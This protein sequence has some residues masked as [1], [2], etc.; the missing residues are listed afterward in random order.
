MFDF[1]F[2]VLVRCYLF[3]SFVFVGLYLEVCDESRGPT[4]R[5]RFFPPRTQQLLQLPLRPHTVF[6]FAKP[7]L[8]C[9]QY[10]TEAQ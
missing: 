1:L 10:N 9:A 7:N 8:S 6:R 2:P 3:M 4:A 5:E